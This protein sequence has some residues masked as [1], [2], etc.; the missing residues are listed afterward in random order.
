MTYDDFLILEAV[1]EYSINES[2]SIPINI[3]K[4]AKKVSEEIK[5]DTASK[6]NDEYKNMSFKEILKD[7]YNK[8]K[9]SGVPEFAG[10][11]G[12]TVG[13]SAAD[14]LKEVANFISK[15]LGEYST[16][17]LLVVAITDYLIGKIS[18]GLVSGWFTTIEW[19]LGI[20][21]FVSLV[22]YVITRKN[23]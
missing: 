13:K 21:I 8:F 9:N 1:Q 12:K 4:T 2:I 11:I 3:N 5:T 22:I 15:K 23:R 10:E 6:V 18:F 7:I 16:I 19:S 20:S 14:I 17:A